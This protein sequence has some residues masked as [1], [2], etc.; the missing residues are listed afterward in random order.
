[1]APAINDYERYH[2]KEALD[3]LDKIKPPRKNALLYLLEK[4][5][6]LHAAGRYEDSI[7][8]FHEAETLSEELYKSAAKQALSVVTNETVLP[9]VGEA[10]ERL[11]IPVWNAL[12]YAAL[13]KIDDA[14]VEV[15][16][17]H[18]LYTSLYGQGLPPPGIENPFAH[19]LSAIIWEAGRLFNDADIDY[20]WA[21]KMKPELP[22]G[23]RKRAD[24]GELI[25]VL[26][27]GL[28]PERFSSE[29]MNPDL[30]QVFPVPRYEARPSRIDHGVVLIGGVE[31]GRT[32]PLASLTKIA[33]AS[34]TAALPALTAKAVGRTVLKEGAAVAV[35]EKV[36]RD[37]G[38]LLGILFLATNQVD[39][40]HWQ[41]LPD[42]L[43][44]ARIPLPEGLT[45]V[46]LRFLDAS[47][48]EVR[49]PVVLPS[50]EVK[51]GEKTFMPYRVFE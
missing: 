26:E 49:A 44:I 6:M 30:L 11:L 39:L 9:Y 47:G 2:Y 35:G 28:S 24:Q 21:H 46:T 16:R 18:T 15:R 42:T 37:L 27:A 36:D 5:M 25:L 43:Q 8:V 17:F 12:N 50:I 34:L 22:L 32:Y 45:H 13:G 7:R 29:W 14:V 38:I 4:G 31:A 51:K 10:Y 20:R 1:M 23:G 19:Y 40:R 3:K 41:T 33:T 48:A